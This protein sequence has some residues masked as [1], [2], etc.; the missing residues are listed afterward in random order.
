MSAL[1][2]MKL[3]TVTGYLAFFLFKPIFCIIYNLHE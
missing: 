3:N 1:P 2:L